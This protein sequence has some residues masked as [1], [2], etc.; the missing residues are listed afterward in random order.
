[1]GSLTF[2]ETLTAAI[3][4]ALENGYDSTSR[5]DY[6][7]ERLRTA[8]V[9]SMAAPHEVERL[10][11]QYLTTVYNRN[12]EKFGLLRNHPD[13]ERFTLQRVKP[14]LREALDRAIYAAAD[15]IKLNKEQA[16]ADTIRRF[17]GWMT[18]IPK[19]GTEVTDRPKVKST[20]KKP[21][22]RQKFEERRVAIDQSAKLVNNLSEILA[23][24][25]GALAG[26]WRSNWR[27]VGYNY[28]EDHKERDEKVYTVRGNWALEQGL[29][30]VGPA[31]YIDEIT[32]PGEEVYCRC[33]YVWI[34]VL[35]KLPANM[36]TAKGRAAI[37]SAIGA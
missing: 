32:R 26:R 22:A 33:Y 9:E 36:L 23:T 25:S 6:W 7:I 4:D 5:L 10:I 24:D 8:A 14:E 21:L 28:R 13:V 3:N 16:V 35:T 31:G 18:S 17:R 27:Q 1:M 12:V 15:Q 20:F 11:K 29:M 2:Q 19:G 37:E 30:K 34:S